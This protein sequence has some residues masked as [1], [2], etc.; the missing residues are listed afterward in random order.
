MRILTAAMLVLVSTIRGACPRGSRNMR[1][2]NESSV[3]RSPTTSGTVAA[4]ASRKP[5][6]PGIPARIVAC[7]VAA[8]GRPEMQI[9]SSSRVIA[10]SFTAGDRVTQSSGWKSLR[11]EGGTLRPM[12]ARGGSASASTRTRRTCSPDCS[13]AVSRAR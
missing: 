12:Q 1:S 6:R 10:A 2:S 11:R 9:S 4:C 8:S 7:V 13:R 5:N 3:E